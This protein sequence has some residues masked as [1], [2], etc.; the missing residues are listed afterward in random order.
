M[1]NEVPLIAIEFGLK[2]TKLFT[3]YTKIKDNEMQ[4]ILIIE[5]LGGFNGAI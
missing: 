1:V 3:N 4:Y 2:E 5:K